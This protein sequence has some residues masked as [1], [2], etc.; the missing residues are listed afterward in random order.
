[1]FTGVSDLIWMATEASGQS[2]MHTVIFRTTY[3][4]YFIIG[5]KLQG[6]AIGRRVKALEKLA[7]EEVPGA[8]LTSAAS[9]EVSVKLERFRGH[10]RAH[11]VMYWFGICFGTYNVAYLVAVTQKMVPTFLPAALWEELSYMLLYGFLVTCILKTLI[12]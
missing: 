11:R 1:M 7:V 12:H 5:C 6:Q 4:L 10:L 3:Y 8:P 9:T 2:A